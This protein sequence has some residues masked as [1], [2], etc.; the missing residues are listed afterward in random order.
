MSNRKALV[1]RICLP[2][3]TNGLLSTAATE[4][5]MTVAEVQTAK[6]TAA[7]PVQIS[8]YRVDGALRG[9]VPR[10]R[11]K[12]SNGKV[13]IR[14]KRNPVVRSAA[15]ETR[16]ACW[17]P[18]EFTALWSQR[19]LHRNSKHT[20]G[21]WY[22]QAWLFQNA[23]LEHFSSPDH[24]YNIAGLIDAARRGSWDI[25]G[26]SD[27]NS[28]HSEVA[29]IAVEEYL[30]IT[31]GKLAFLLSPAMSRRWRD[32]GAQLCSTSWKCGSFQ[33]CTKSSLG[34]MC[35]QPQP[36]LLFRGG[37]CAHGAQSF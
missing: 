7:T 24:Q 31:F 37:L 29:M 16:R 18:L 34:N 3:D 23:G 12:L 2:R 36:G 28:S 32:G 33:V 5:L 27:I 14:S 19:R 26:I 35:S 11:F 30:F 20:C 6:D 17:R 13:G 22:S 8:C 15:Q 25:V 4:T 10:P 21:Q 1:V 9:G